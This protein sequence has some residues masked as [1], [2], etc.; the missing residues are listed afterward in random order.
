MRNWGCLSLAVCASFAIAPAAE[1]QRISEHRDDELLKLVKP[2]S[3]ESRFFRNSL[4]FEFGRGS[5]EGS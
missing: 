1:P 5:Q 3:G 2:Q 4:A